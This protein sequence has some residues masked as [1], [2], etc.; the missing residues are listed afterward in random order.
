MQQMPCLL[1]GESRERRTDKNGKPYFVCDPC[2]IQLFIRRAA[3]A[4]RL[5][6]MLDHIARRELA[7]GNAAE[8]LHEL[9]A[10]VREIEGLEKEI[11][12]ADS[13]TGWLLANDNAVRTREALK[14]R[15]ETAFEKLE[16][17]CGKRRTP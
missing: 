15:R 2:G 12:R 16:L 8:S 9:Q 14:A 17:L 6:A 10:L 11:E 13:Q 5:D 1:C 3:G 4:R 7:F